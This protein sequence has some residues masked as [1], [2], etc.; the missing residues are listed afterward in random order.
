LKIVVADSRVSEGNHDGSQ[1][2]RGVIAELED[3]GHQVDAIELP[4]H[5]RTNL[6]TFDLDAELDGAELVLVSA[7]TD[8]APIA[9]SGAHRARHDGYRLLFHDTRPACPA[10]EEAAQLDLSNY[11]GVLTRGE[12]L[13]RLYLERSWAGQA[14]TWHEAVDTRVFHPLPAIEPEA[15]LVWIGDWGEGARRRELRDFLLCPARSARMHG[16]LYG[17]GYPASARLRIRLSGL[18]YCG[19][20]PSDRAA[21][22]F[23]RHRLTVHLPP[24]GGEGGPPDAPSGSFFEALACGIPLISAPWDDAE[25]LFRPEQ[26]YLIARDCAEMREAMQAILEFPEFAAQLRESGLET[27]RARHTCAHRA[28]ELL[29]I[30]AELRGTTLELAG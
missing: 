26:D 29:A 8:P 2:L 22:L 13:R 24:G 7:Q 16:H 5:S 20:K 11:D 15:D 18:H 3:R 6:E 27:I 12:A 25:G 10:A 9:R 17:D 19:P 23:A 14:W 28:E 1:F 4:G 21:E 30:D